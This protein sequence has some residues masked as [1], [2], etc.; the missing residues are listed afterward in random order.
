MSDDFSWLLFEGSPFVP[1]L[2]HD[3]LK[4]V[5]EFT[6]HSH[7]SPRAAVAA[8]VTVIGTIQN[9]IHQRNFASISYAYGATAKN[10]INY[11]MGFTTPPSLILGGY[12][13]KY[14]TVKEALQITCASV[15]LEDLRL[16]NAYKARYLVEAGNIYQSTSGRPLLDCASPIYDLCRRDPFS[17]DQY[18]LVGLEASLVTFAKLAIA[19]DLLQ[20]PASSLKNTF[21]PTL[22]GGVFISWTCPEPSRR[23]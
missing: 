9:V 15:E 12:L 6:T 13:L 19:L 21:F 23:T 3:S 5:I 8:E 10:L 18:F 1:D 22:T 2:P 7:L 11:L 16:L 17:P 4:H 14:R 20:P